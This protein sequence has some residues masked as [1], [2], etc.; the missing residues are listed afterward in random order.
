MWGRID[1][2]QDI[3]VISLTLLFTVYSKGQTPSVKARTY[4]KKDAANSKEP[5]TW[6]IS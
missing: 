6:Y 1:I 2:C 5:Y 3:D 4:D